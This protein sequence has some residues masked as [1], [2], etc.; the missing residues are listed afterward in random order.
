M[1]SLVAGTALAALAA[2]GWLKPPP[3]LP[4]V[5][6][7]R[8]VLDF[9]DA[10]PP[11]P[12]DDVVISPDG[13]RFAAVLIVG[14]EVGLYVR[15]ADQ[16]DFRLL[17]EAGSAEFLIGPSFSPDG[18]WIVYGTGRALFR[19]AV[20]GGAPRPVLQEGEI[21]ARGFHWEDDENNTLSKGLRR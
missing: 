15:N 1:T 13:S 2:W 18:Q 16:E 21:Q 14:G 11:L 3:P 19:I 6:P 8:T 17:I 12:F 9:G 4:A 10:T 7:T 20:S 5:Q